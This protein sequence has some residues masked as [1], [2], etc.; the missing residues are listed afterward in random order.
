M[1]A[2][3][4]HRPLAREQAEFFAENGY[5]HV[6]GAFA[7]D[8]IDRLKALVYRL[9][10]KFAPDDGA[11][12][13]LDRPWEEAAFDRKMIALRA[14]RPDVFGALYDSAQSSA[15]LF[16]LLA[17]PAAL[18]I[19]AGCL[20]ERPEDLSCSGSG[21]MLR[22]DPPKDRRNVLDWHQDRSYFQQNVNGANGL[23][24]TVPLQDTPAE[25][26]A[27]EICPGSHKEGFVRAEIENKKDDI[28]TQQR[29]VPADRIARY[30]KTIVGAKAGDA[31][32][33]EMNLFHRSGVNQS[34]RIRYSAIGRYH[35]MMAEDFVPF[36]LE[37]VFS[38][39]S[40]AVVKG[41]REK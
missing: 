13:G 14:A 6:A 17:S 39:S 5:L 41:A 33:I 32:V 31:F 35:R 20:G 18:A 12:D 29:L 30:E 22:M 7:R 38:D 11:L 24:L 37:H 2:A 16:R 26:G 34:E 21:H 4:E 9:Y 19:A 28:T 15:E 10:R 1:S 8:E 36:R 27:L 23:V 3:M 25:L 40:L